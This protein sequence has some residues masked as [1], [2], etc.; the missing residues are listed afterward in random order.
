M[1]VKPLKP[2]SRGPTTMDS[3][4]SWNF[5]CIFNI[6]EEKKILGPQVSTLLGNYVV[7]TPGLSNPT[8]QYSN[9]LGKLYPTPRHPYLTH[10]THLTH[11]YFP[12]M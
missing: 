9:L 2:M 7:P 8:R 4:F 11:S 10:P 12:T 3:F 6:V 1:R 5:L